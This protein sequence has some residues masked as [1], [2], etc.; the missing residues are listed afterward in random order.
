M[1]TIT[2]YRTKPYMSKAETAEMMTL[3]AEIG[4]AAGTVAHYVDASGGGGWVVQEG[5][6][7]TVDYVNTLR[8][9]PYLEFEVSI[10][11]PV[12]QAVPDILAAL[13]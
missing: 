7:P 9:S 2:R 5:Q 3:F 13:A 6:D 10:V 4:E 12:D 1:M 8:Y 11:M